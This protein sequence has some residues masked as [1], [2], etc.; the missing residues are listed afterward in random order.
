MNHAAAKL[1]IGSAVPGDNYYDPQRS[2]PSLPWLVDPLA[3]FSKS[4]VNTLNFE[5]TFQTTKGLRYFGV[6]LERMLDI[7]EKYSGVVVLLN[8]L[9]ER[10]RAAVME[11]RERLARELHDSVTQSLY[12]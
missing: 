2:A 10:K 7:S 4:E 9:T 1:L 12:S 8:D 6:K 5:R 11:E 3:T